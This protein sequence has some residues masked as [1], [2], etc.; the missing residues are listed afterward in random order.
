[1]SDAICTSA[2]WAK[3]WTPN[4]VEYQVESSDRSQSNAKN[5]SVSAEDDQARR[6]RSSARRGV[7]ERLGL[8]L[9]GRPA[10]RSRPASQYQTQEVDDEPAEEEL[11]G[12]GRTRLCSTIS[13]RR[14]PRRCS[15]RFALG[16]GQVAVRRTA[17]SPT[18]PRVLLERALA[19]LL[20]RAAPRLGVVLGLARPARER[21][22]GTQSTSGM[23]RIAKMGIG[24]M[25]SSAVRRT[26]MPQRGLRDVQH[27][28]EEHAAR[29]RR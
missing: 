11:L 2:H 14:A 19:G 15:I 22:A 21:A 5:V 4:I 24:R 25:K 1:M 20:R 3:T 9:I 6:A 23:T 27:E 28:H 17:R 7:L 13:A 26:V 16:S 12:P 10:G 18:K 8:V 29:A